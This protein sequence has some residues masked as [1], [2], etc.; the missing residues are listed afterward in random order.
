MVIMPA[1][2]LQV[3]QGRRGG[4]E[5][6]GHHHSHVLTALSPCVLPLAAAG[7]L[8]GFQHLDQS[9]MWEYMLAR[10]RAITIHDTRL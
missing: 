10:L 4:R 2:I 9:E 5:G 8:P 6:G 7:W 1:M 3:A